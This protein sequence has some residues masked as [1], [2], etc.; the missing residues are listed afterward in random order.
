MNLE[1]HLKETG[2]WVLNRDKWDQPEYYF[3]TYE[4]D[5]F[6]CFIHDDDESWWSSDEQEVEKRNSMSDSISKE[7]ALAVLQDAD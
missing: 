6:L 7:M 4:D 2:H 3:P 5:L 1:K